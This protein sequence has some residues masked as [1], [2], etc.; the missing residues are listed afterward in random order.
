M[1]RKKRLGG[2]HTVKVTFVLPP[3]QPFG[4]CSVVGSFNGWDPLAHP[5]KR[6]S[7]R[8]F[9]AA[10]ELPA[11]GRFAFRYLGEGG[12]WFDEPEADGWEGTGDGRHNC[13]IHT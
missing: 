8:T 3:D 13:V 2:D 7:N 12:V 9:S 1:I 6:R 4:K 5:L 11:D 10:V